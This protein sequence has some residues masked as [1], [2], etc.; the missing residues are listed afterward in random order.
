MWNNRGNNRGR[1]IG[2]SHLFLHPRL[3]CLG[4]DIALGRN[5]CNGYSGDRVFRRQGIPGTVYCFWNTGTQSLG[6]SQGKGFDCAI[7]PR[8]VRVL[9]YI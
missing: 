9:T 6:F 7:F 4:L 1:I 2:D 8:L 5:D 3:Y